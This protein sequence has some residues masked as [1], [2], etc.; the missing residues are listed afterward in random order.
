[1][2]QASKFVASETLLSFVPDAGESIASTGA[3]E[4][5]TDALA[6]LLNS[7]CWRPFFFPAE[8]Q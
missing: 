5:D 3:L 2:V 1:M 6:D 8:P 7:D 4:D